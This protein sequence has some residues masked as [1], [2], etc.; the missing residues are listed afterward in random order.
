VLHLVKEN[1]GLCLEQGCSIEIWSK[2]VTMFENF[3]ESIKLPQRSKNNL[4]LLAKSL[5]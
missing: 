5:S 2:V 1:D 4:E 3:L